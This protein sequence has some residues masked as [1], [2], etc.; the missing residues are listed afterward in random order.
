VKLQ[1]E[2]SK[3]RKLRTFIKEH[4]KGYELLSKKLIRRVKELIKKK[5]R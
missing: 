2:E 1:H 5:E 3:N 4:E